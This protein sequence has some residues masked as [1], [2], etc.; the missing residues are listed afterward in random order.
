MTELPPEE[1]ERL[2]TEVHE[3]DELFA[4]ARELLRAQGI[5]PATV[6]VLEIVRTPFRL[7]HLVGISVRQVADPAEKP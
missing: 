6:R 4:Q 3:A 7:L 2:W 1:L 5:D